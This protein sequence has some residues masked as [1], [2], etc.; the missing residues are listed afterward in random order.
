MI[1]A[2]KIVIVDICGTMFDSNTTYDFMDFAIQSVKYRWFRAI[3]KTILFKAI[4]KIFVLTGHDFTRYIMLQFIRGKSKSELGQLMENYY[5]SFLSERKIKSVWEEL[6]RLRHQGYTLIL[7]SATLDFIAEYI[8]SVNNIDFVFSTKLNYS[9]EIFCG[10][11]KNNLYGKKDKIILS[12]CDP[13]AVKMVI[14][15][16]MSDIKLISISESALIVSENSQTANWKKLLKTHK[17][18]NYKFITV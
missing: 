15:N 17:I 1:S 9:S 13:A 6:S 3:S 7:A 4:N 5:R 12:F 18:K 8:A 11:I 10:T 2:K 16:D 14:T